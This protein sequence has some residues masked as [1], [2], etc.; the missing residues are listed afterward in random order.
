MNLHKLKVI[1]FHAHFP[2]RW[3]R[4]W[5]TRLVEIYGERKAEKIIENRA[6]YRVDWRKA[7]GF[8]PPE[9]ETRS[10]EEQARRWATDID[11]KGVEKVNFVMG[12]G[13]DRLANIVSLF[14]EKFTGFAHHDIRGEQAPD[15]VERAVKKLGLKG[16][17]LIASSQEHPI[18][19][20]KLY[21]VWDKISELKIPVVIH[22]GVLGGGG[23]P[24]RNLHNMNPLSL[25]PIASDYPEIEFIVPHFG[26]CYIREL[27]ELCWNAPNVSVDSSGSNQWMR[28]MPYQLTIKDLFRKYIETIGADRIIFG[29]DSSYFP[30]GFSEA[31]LR[32]QVKACYEIGLTKTQME[33]IFYGNSAR[34]LKIK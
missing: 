32:E 3:R 13:N 7:W 27:L 18:E 2:I 21:P 4:D 15:E 6:M 25:W 24:A 9:E 30:R 16:F 14:P 22:F 8:A 31:Y 19:D 20:K 10:D 33:K 5:R 29:T 28:W 26:A 17:K 34:L 12:G 23:G 1:D 11:Q